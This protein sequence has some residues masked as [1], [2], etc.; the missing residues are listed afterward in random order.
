MTQNIKIDTEMYFL[1]SV[2]YIEI[3]FNCQFGNEVKF[4]FLLK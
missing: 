2:F 3:N 4:Q 1:N